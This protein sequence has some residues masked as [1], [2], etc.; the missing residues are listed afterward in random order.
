MIGLHGTRQLLRP[1]HFWEFYTH[2]RKGPRLCGWA[3]L[4]MSGAFPE[5]QFS[6]RNVGDVPSTIEQ[7][8]FLHRKQGFSELPFHVVGPKSDVLRKLQPG[9]HVE[10]R[11]W[12]PICQD[13][14]FQIDPSLQSI[15][16]GWLVI[17]HSASPKPVFCRI[18]STNERRTRRS[19]EQP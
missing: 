1:L 17:Y 11:L 12:P 10:G 5:I 18:E 7:F 13:G 9:E 19:T 3:S 6:I 15:D 2:F 16:S 8:A 14:T 4:N